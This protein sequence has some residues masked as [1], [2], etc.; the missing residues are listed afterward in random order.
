[1]KFVEFERPEF[2]FFKSN[3]ENKRCRRDTQTLTLSLLLLLLPP[4]THTHT[5]THTG[6]TSAADFMFIVFNAGDE[7]QNGFVLEGGNSILR[8]ARWVGRGWMD[9]WVGEVGND[10]PINQT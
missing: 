6:H 5:L 1:M 2:E 4:L 3:K 8:R 10:D 7:E 9:G